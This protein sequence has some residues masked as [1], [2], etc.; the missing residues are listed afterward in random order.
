M[1]GVCQETI[2][3]QVPHSLGTLVAMEPQCRALPA[4]SSGTAQR[5]HI[6]A[7]GCQEAR[8][9]RDFLR[10]CLLFADVSQDVLQGQTHQGGR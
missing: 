2:S 10:N 1:L 3:Q 5:M 6:G 4:G 8:S 7:E 9:S